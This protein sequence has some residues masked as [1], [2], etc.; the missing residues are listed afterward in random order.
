MR[1]A[2]VIFGGDQ[3]RERAPPPPPPRGPP[4]GGGPHNRF[5]FLSP[6]ILSPFPF[7]FLPPPPPPGDTLHFLVVVSGLHP[8]PVPGSDIVADVADTA[9][10]RAAADAGAAE[11][12]Q[13]RFGSACDAAGV[14]HKFEVARFLTD[15]RS[16]ADA[17]AARA[18]EI[19]AALVAIASHGKGLLVRLLAGSVSA[20]V[21]AR[22]RVP[23]LLVQ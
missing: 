9:G 18:A 4:G 12:M 21:A 22:C 5:I 10:E 15:A 19:D 11:F 6:F 17:V 2:R 23:V 16:V 14:D 13:R 20:E 3:K 8:A 1:S 7:I